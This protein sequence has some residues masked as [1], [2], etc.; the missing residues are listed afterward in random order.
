MKDNF[1]YKKD[2]DIFNRGYANVK[3]GKYYG[4]IAKEIFEKNIE[5]KI[6]V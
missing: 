6:R 5:K 2:H 1:D 3:D 4:K